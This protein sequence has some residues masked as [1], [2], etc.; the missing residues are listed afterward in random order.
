MYAPTKDEKMLAM[1]CHLSGI[2]TG[3]VGPL[4]FWLIKKDESPFMN[5]QGKEA[6]NFQITLFIIHAALIVV[7][8]VSCGIT[9]PLSL[10]VWLGSIVLMVMAALKANE[11]VPYRYPATLRLVK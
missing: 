5:D 8:I 1:L 9:L 10:V 2:L 6:L 11:G 3:F 7:S 4:V